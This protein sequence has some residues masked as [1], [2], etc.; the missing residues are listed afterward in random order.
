MTTSMLALHASE[1]LLL[2]DSISIQIMHDK[3][4]MKGKGLSRFVM[5]FLHPS[6]ISKE[7]YENGKEIEL[8][9]KR[10]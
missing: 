7:L 2:E 6:Y 9:E 3:K 1:T 8:N 10:F 5:I 4:Q